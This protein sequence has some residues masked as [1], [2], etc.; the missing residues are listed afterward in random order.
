MCSTRA[1]SASDALREAHN[2]VDF[3]QANGMLYDVWAMLAATAAVLVLSPVAG[4]VV[5]KFKPA[6]PSRKGHRLATTIEQQANLQQE[7]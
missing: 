7:L 1:P 3:S 4:S 6:A 2:A 5:R